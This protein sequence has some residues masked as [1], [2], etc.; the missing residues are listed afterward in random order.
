M[1]FYRETII[2]RPRPPNGLGAAPARLVGDRRAAGGKGWISDHSASSERRRFFRMLAAL[3]CATKTGERQVRTGQRGTRP[4]LAIWAAAF[5]TLLGVAG[6]TREQ[7]PAPA[8]AAPPAAPPPAA[9][10]AAAAI[11]DS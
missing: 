9:P 1:V 5:V 6:C 10:T 2:W 8:P 11:R 7:P 4:A 3:F